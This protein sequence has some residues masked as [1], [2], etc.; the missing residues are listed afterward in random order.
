MSIQSEITRIASA[1]SDIAD[2]I[3]EKGVEVPSGSMIDDMAE[4]ILQIRSS[5]VTIT[6]TPDIAGGTIVTIDTENATTVTPLSVT[7]SGTYTA[8]SGYAYS[9]VVVDVQ[10][11]GGEDGD[12][13]Y[14][15]N[16]DSNKV[17]LGQID[18][19]TL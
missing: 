13:L 18:Y 5:G 3:E 16:R 15:G 2:A 7:E 1:K 9:P 10:G 19:C 14:Y 6:E 17:S 4:L 11:G 12:S 8:P